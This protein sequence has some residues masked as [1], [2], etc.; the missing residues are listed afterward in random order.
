MIPYLFQTI[1]VF[2]IIIAIIFDLGKVSYKSYTKTFK[3]IYIVLAILSALRYGVGADTPSYMVAYEY[4]PNIKD[5]NESTFLFFRFQ[6]LY[7]IV[8]SI[9]KTIYQDFVVVQIIQC[10]LFFHSFYLLI[11][12]FH[13]KKMYLLLIF[14]CYVYFSS[15]MTLMRESYALAFCFYGIYFYYKF[16]KVKWFY[17][18]NIIGFFFHSSVI[19]LFIIPILN[20]FKLRKNIFFFI[21]IGSSL[22]CLWAAFNVNSSIMLSSSDS[23]INR[24]I[25]TENEN[26]IKFFGVIRVIIEFM[27]FYLYCFK[28]IKRIPQ[29]IVY[30]GLLYLV[31]DIGAVLYLDILS[32]FSSHFTIF[33]FICLDSILKKKNIS[34]SIKA[35]ILLLFLY[36]PIS[37]C[38]NIL[39]VSEY[40]M[41]MLEYC[42]IFSEDK[43]YYNKIIRNTSAFDY[44]IH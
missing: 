29:D 42:S 41:S 24:Y 34:S 15:G 6:P 18:L 20:K 13:I 9:C 28:D 25:G 7:I 35:I 12:Y 17:I 38:I 10:I 23:S 39:F 32:R 27:I 11:D 37:R 26:G 21:F 1:F 5:L 4:I 22:I 36:Q 30:L 16:G 2:L 33:F 3:C 43:T 31:F 40:N 8:N 19:V 14:Y 44:F